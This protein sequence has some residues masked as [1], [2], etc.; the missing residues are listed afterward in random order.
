MDNADERTSEVA[1]SLA[2]SKSKAFIVLCLP[3]LPRPLSKGKDI[4]KFP[5]EVHLKLAAALISDN[6][7]HATLVES[8]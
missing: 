7:Y 1:I 4:K 3:A 8:L 2:I 6:T 5:K